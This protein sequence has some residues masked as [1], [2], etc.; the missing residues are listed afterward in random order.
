MVCINYSW[1]G[2]D[3]MLWPMLDKNYTN[4]WSRERHFH[5]MQGILIEIKNLLGLQYDFR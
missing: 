5:M 2:R 1:H 3:D 4:T